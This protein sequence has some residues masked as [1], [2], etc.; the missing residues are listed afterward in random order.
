MKAVTKP[1]YIKKM[2]NDM[3]LLPLDQNALKLILAGVD[4]KVQLGTAPEDWS[5]VLSQSAPSCLE[6]ALPL[7][8]HIS[9]HDLLHSYLYSLKKNRGC[10]GV[11]APFPDNLT[12]LFPFLGSNFLA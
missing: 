1:S 12:R 2:N 9:S 10:S 3:L 8:S 7:V 4:S 6:I 11:F 5:I